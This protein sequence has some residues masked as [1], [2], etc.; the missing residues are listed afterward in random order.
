MSFTDGIRLTED[1]IA[2]KLPSTRNGLTI[3]LYQLSIVDSRWLIDEL[4]IENIITF[5]VSV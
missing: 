2:M 1:S 3:E 5:E 4:I